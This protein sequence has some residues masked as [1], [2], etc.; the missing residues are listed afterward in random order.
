MSNL[1]VAEILDSPQIEAPGVCLSYPTL[2]MGYN[3]SL[4][5]DAEEFEWSSVL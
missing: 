3:N 2:G 4:L 1:I 5:D